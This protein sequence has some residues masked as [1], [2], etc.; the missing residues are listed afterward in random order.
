MTKS[1]PCAV[2]LPV[3]ELVALTGW[4]TSCQ[5]ICNTKG[6]QQV[7]FCALQC[8]NEYYLL[9][10]LICFQDIGFQDRELLAHKNDLTL[11]PNPP[12]TLKP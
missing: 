2:G 3:P 7:K 4:D 12:I 10:P 11:N 8:A 5:Q 1:H 9:Q 6:P